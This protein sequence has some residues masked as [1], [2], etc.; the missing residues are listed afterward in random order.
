MESALG[1]L[2]QFTYDDARQIDTV[3][4]S[5]IDQPIDYDFD[6]AGNR[7]VVTNADGSTDEFIFDSNN[8]LIADQQYHYRYNQEGA[9]TLR[10]PRQ[11]GD[12]PHRNARPQ[13]IFTEL[14]R[15]S[16]SNSAVDVQF[17]EIANVGDAEIDITGWSIGGAVSAT[18]DGNATLHPGDAAVFSF[19]TTDL[20]SFYDDDSIPV[21]GSFA[22]SGDGLPS[23]DRSNR[24]R[25]VE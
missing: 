12:Q 22:N 10:W 17:V 6:A 2:Q 18:I 5:V 19:D 1:G 23:T 11:P 21:L 25:P 4:L 7:S 15:D 14:M 13:V 24:N 8:Q 3:Q 20:W 16:W 9:R